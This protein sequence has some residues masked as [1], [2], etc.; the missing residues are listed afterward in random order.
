MLIQAGLESENSPEEWDIQHPE[1]VCS[2]HRQYIQAG[3]QIILTNSFGGI[4]LM[5][6][7]HQ[8]GNRVF[9]LNLAAAE[10]ARTEADAADHLVL[11]INK[12][13]LFV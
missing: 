8:L 5:L 6:G 12:N 10:I 7:L 3:S 2:V 4:S 1:K 9:E 13:S 11:V